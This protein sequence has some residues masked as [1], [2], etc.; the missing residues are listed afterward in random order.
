MRSFKQFLADIIVKIL[1]LVGQLIV[2]VI[3]SGWFALLAYILNWMGASQLWVGLLLIISGATFLAGLA[4][5]FE[6]RDQKNN[7]PQRTLVNSLPRESIKK[8]TPYRR[9]KSNQDIPR[10]V[11]VPPPQQYTP[12]EYTLPKQ[13]T[14]T[15]NQPTNKTQTKTRPNTSHYEIPYKSNRANTEESPIEEIFRLNL[16]TML[17]SADLMRIQ[18]QYPVSPYF[19]DFAIPDKKIAVELDGHDWHKTKEQRTHDA[20]KDRHLQ[21]LGWLVIRFTGSEIYKDSQKCVRELAELANIQL[22]K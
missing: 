9:I 12:P 18:T 1:L 4:S 13:H 14:P 7:Q 20:Q 16:N 3:M 15:E 19:L 11:Y 6:T 8:V 2:L 17:G 5:F 10:T 21:K 22:K